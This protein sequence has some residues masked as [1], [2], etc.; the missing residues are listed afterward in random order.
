[1]DQPVTSQ[2]RKVTV[3]KDGPYIVTGG[4]P[5]AKEIIINDDNEGCPTEWGAGDK[6]PDKE[7][8]SLCR[9]GQSAHKPFC[10]GTHAKAGF[11][12][13]ETASREPYLDRAE[14]IGGKDIALLD[15]QEL[16]S[17]ARFCHQGRGIWQIAASQ[18]NEK[19]RERAEH[20]AGQCPAGR[21][22]IWD[23]AKEA[24][25]EPPFEPSISLVEDPHK[26]VSGGL[27]LKG[28]ILLES[29]DGK[30]Y[31]TRNR[32][33]LCRCGQS[34]NKPFC[35]GTHIDVGFTDGDESLK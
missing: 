7:T 11:D 30:P 3:S 34:G 13:T 2:P 22:V 1:L 31:E 35:D 12:G 33:T 20:V 21:L 9:C 27:W 17:R 26:H 6:Y 29:A 28:G 24:T 32:V 8:Y 14:A 25:V 4:L 23:K 5:L 16:C 15:V 19:G 18:K 10:D